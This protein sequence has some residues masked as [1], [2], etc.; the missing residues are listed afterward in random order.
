MKGATAYDE[1]GAG[2]PLILIHGLGLNRHMWQW[3]RDALAVDFRVVAYDLLGHG[4]SAKPQGPIRMHQMVA[5]ITTLMRN[6]HIERA[7][8]VGFSLGGLIARAFALAHLR[9]VSALVIL[10]S[11]H[12]RSAQERAAIMARVKQVEDGGPEA[13]VTAALERWF[14]TDFARTHP[15]VLETV[16]QWVVTNDPKVYPALYRLFAQADVGLETRIS[17]IAQPVLIVASENDRGNSPHMA[18]QMAA[19]LPNA[20]VEILPELRHMALA[21]DPQQVNALLLRFLHESLLHR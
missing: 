14:S 9:K 11:A 15:Q 10:N 7:A 5:Q 20:R 21:E 3:Q 6:L 12:A 13:T 18:R 19:H 1:V 17:A 4:D 8:L 16:R 2:P